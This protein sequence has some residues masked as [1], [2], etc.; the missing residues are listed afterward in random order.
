MN[1]TIC[2]EP[3][4][5]V[6]WA[7]KVQ[8]R[9]FYCLGCLKNIGMSDSRPYGWDGIQQRPYPDP[10]NEYWHCSLLSTVS[11]RVVD[12]VERIRRSNHP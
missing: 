8:Y 11:T 6:Q 4:D 1:C 5:V 9:Y 12:R 7:D 2:R 10:E 3:A